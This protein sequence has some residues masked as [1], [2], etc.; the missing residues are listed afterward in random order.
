MCVG[1][2]VSDTRPCA[3]SKVTLRMSVS[4]TRIVCGDAAETSASE[5]AIKQTTNT[6]LTGTA[7][8]ALFVSFIEE[9]FR[10]KAKP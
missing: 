1:S 6:A 10:K 2:I 7:R 3:P 5:A 8:R 4:G 9:P